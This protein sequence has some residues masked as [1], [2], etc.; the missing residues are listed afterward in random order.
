MSGLS[1]QNVDFFLKSLRFILGHKYRQRRSVLLLSEHLSLS[2]TWVWMLVTGV[3][4]KGLV[5]GIFIPKTQ[6]YCF[7]VLVMTRWVPWDRC[8]S[9]PFSHR[10]C[11]KGTREC[12]C[13]APAH[14]SMMLCSAFLAL[15]IGC[16]GEDGTL[17]P[18][19]ILEKHRHVCPTHSARTA[20]QHKSRNCL[21]RIL[22]LLNS[23]NV[24]NSP[25]KQGHRSF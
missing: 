23:L 10:K 9:F 19:E 22:G 5:Q 24:G 18:L 12:L 17:V 11:Y 6:R 14:C 2:G 20:P 25:K 1:L 4:V 8:A 16:S 7:P 13:W 15:R 3:A 21:M